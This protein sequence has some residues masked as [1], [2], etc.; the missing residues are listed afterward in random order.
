MNWIDVKD[1]LPEYNR[2]CA[3][4]ANWGDSIR[5]RVIAKYYV[6]NEWSCYQ[7]NGKPYGKGMVEF[8]MYLPEM[9]EKRNET[10]T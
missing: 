9:P 3:V 7:D 1:Q 2:V 8:W 5:S 6:S 10:T 4:V